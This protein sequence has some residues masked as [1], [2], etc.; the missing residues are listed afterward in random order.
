MTQYSWN[1]QKQFAIAPMMA[2]TDRHCRVFHRTLTKRA[3]LFTEM[4]TSGAVIHGNREKI[5]GFSEI[6]HPLVC[7]IGGSNPLELAESAKIIENFGYDEINLN[8]G[9]PSNR[10]QNGN[11]GACLMKTPELVG[12]CV[13][14]MKEVVDIPVTVKCRLGVDDQD[15]EV[16][17]DEFSDAVVA[18]GVDGIWV[19]ARKALLAG[20]SPKKNREIPPLD[21]ERVY[22]IKA[23]LP[24]V[25]IGI[26]GGIETMDE[27]LVHL[28][29]VDAVMIG[30]VAYQNPW[31]LTQVDETIYGV[32]PKTVERKKVI[33]EF[34]QYVSDQ[35]TQGVRLCSLTKHMLGLYQGRPGARNWRR[36]LTTDSIINGAG[37]E[38]IETAM[39]MA[40]RTR[41]LSEQI[42]RQSIPLQ[43]VA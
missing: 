8:V 25:F 31:M 6:E 12:E 2:W 9:C 22:R 39:N 11:F 38:T 24:R 37:L 3:L 43:Q 33:A 10:V 36:I 27:C 5:L 19:H 14:S 21:Y 34:S 41:D 40:D 30:R 28:E 16:A 1:N 20:L 13:F 23:R 29:K 7:Q 42:N 17:L 26:N 18:A 4:V 35:L 15:T 32:P